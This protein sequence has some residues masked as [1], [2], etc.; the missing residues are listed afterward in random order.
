M[1]ISTRLNRRPKFPLL[2]SLKQVAEFIK[3]DFDL[4]AHTLCSNLGRGFLVVRDTS[5]ELFKIVL[6]AA[7]LTAA[8]DQ[9]HRLGVGHLDGL[10]MA[11]LTIVFQ[12]NLY[13][14][15]RPLS[16]TVAETQS[17]REYRY[18]L[19]R[20]SLAI[21]SDFVL[22]PS[23]PGYNVQPR[24]AGEVSQLLLAID[25]EDTATAD[26]DG[27]SDILLWAT[28]MG[29]IAANGAS[30]RRRWYQE[31]LYR[32]TIMKGISFTQLTNCMSTLLWWDHVFEDRLADL[33]MEALHFGQ[34]QAVASWKLP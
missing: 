3:F 22:F 26:G 33:W 17:L 1:V 34:P 6:R 30:S 32:Q 13:S 16:T 31:R 20:V 27:W 23:T 24:L 29:G 9:L 18:D 11:M 25:K 4:E 15:S 5:S 7:E 8:L 21:Y 28:V 19:C 2:S 10:E 14:L 12:H